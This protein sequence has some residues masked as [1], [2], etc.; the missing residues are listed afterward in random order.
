MKQTLKIFAGSVA[1]YLAL[2][3]CSGVASQQAPQ[4]ELGAIHET[5]Q[6]GEP[7]TAP[8]GASAHA[9]GGIMDPVL[10]AM[11]AG[12]AGA[13]NQEKQPQ[14]CAARE[15]VLVEAKCSIQAT[16]GVMFAEAAFD[17][18]SAEELAGVVAFVQFDHTF[19]SKY[20]GAAPAEYSAQASNVFLRDGFVATNCGQAPGHIATSVKFILR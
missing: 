10:P 7:A 15:P 5:G 20:P 11:A 17:G 12:E 13:G 3:A 8:V 14:P 6:G 1:V 16:G 9:G 4:A 19:A 18:Y 2:A